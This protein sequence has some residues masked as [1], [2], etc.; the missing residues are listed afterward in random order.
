MALN[1]VYRLFAA[2]GIGALVSGCQTTPREVSHAE[3]K[4]RNGRYE[5]ALLDYQRALNTVKQPSAAEMRLRYN[6]GTTYYR[7]D[8]TRSAVAE[9]LPAA[10]RAATARDRDAGAFRVRAFYN[11]ANAFYREDDYARAVDAYV[12]ALKVDPHDADAKHN[13]ELALEQ[14]EQQSSA[15]GS[16]EPDN[17]NPTPTP[18]E[19]DREPL[20]QNPAGLSTDQARRLLDMLGSDNLSR[21]RDRTTN[22]VPPRYDVEKDW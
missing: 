17:P 9:L 1:T 10:E 13:L 18:G 21:Q 4:Y 20:P 5:S 6:I 7:M 14:L 15:G 2:L 16:P 3:I 8:Q 19:G 11:L 22:L 12:A